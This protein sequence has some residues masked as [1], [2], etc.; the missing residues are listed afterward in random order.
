[1]TQKTA[2]SFSIA[3]SFDSRMKLKLKNVASITSP[4]L[5]E[6]DLRA[7]DAVI[8]ASHRRGRYES[9]NFPG[10]RVPSRN[11]NRQAVVSGDNSRIGTPAT[12]AEKQ[13]ISGNDLGTFESVEDDDLDHNAPNFKNEVSKESLSSYFAKMQ[14]PSYVQRLKSQNMLLN[15]RSR[16]NTSS[17][18]RQDSNCS[19]DTDNQLVSKGSNTWGRIRTSIAIASYFDPEKTVKQF[20]VIYA[21]MNDNILNGMKRIWT[22]FLY[23]FLFSE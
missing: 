19:E 13:R 16:I 21:D 14:K 5:L 2:D 15:S 11:G 9:N 23:S 3:S 17:L 10:S 4:T 22:L 1:M 6:S 20:Q 8:I 12:T 7:A 18:T